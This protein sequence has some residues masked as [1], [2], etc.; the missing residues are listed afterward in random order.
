MAMWTI[1]LEVLHIPQQNQYTL[2]FRISLLQLL[3]FIMRVQVSYAAICLTIIAATI[4]SADDEQIRELLDLAQNR[5]C[6][7][8]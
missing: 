7:C 8:C 5:N 3:R 6:G 1:Q 2:G 4:F